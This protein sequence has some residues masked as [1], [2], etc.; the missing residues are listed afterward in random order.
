MATFA[1]N[2]SQGARLLSAEFDYINRGG[3]SFYYSESQSVSTSDTEVAVGSS[4]A[5][6]VPVWVISGGQSDVEQ[7][8]PVTVSSPSAVPTGA[9]ETQDI[10]NGAVTSAKLDTNISIGGTTATV[11]GITTGGATPTTAAKGVTFGTGTGPATLYR[12]AADT[13][14]TD[15]ALTV[16]GALT[17][18]A[19]ATVATTLGVT[20][21][22]TTTGGIAGGIPRNIGTWQPIAA[23]SGTDTACSNGTVYTGSVFVPA[24]VTVTGI[25]YLVGSVGGTDSVVVALYNKTGTLVANSATA[26]AT[27][28]T[29]AQIQQVAFDPGTY[30]AVGPAWYHIGLCFNG[31][32]A[33]FRTVPAHCNA[34]N[35]VVGNG[36]AQTFGTPATITAPT[37]FTA[38][39]VPVA[40]LY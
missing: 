40:S 21:A 9:V 1:L 15:D 10:Q 13:L 20:G 37:T 4:L 35:G 25:Q 28:G 38:D 16:A 36:V 30:A 39:K 31:T 27:V 32:T 26:G 14:K 18:E 11:G 23:T 33:K 22:T 17:A 2:A 24:N 7:I 3:S 29:A 19:A 34:G 5:S 12:S 8:P 6:R